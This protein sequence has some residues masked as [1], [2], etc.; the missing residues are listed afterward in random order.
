MGNAVKYS[1]TRRWVRVSLVRGPS[2]CRVSVTDRGEGIPPESMERLFQRFFRDPGTQTRIQGL[3]IG[4]AVVK[5]IMDAHGGAVEVKSA[6]GKGSTFT[7]VFPVPA[8]RTGRP[9]RTARRTT[10]GRR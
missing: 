5:H 9:R 2:A 10:K 1:V 8:V 6:P 7:L 3:G 4:L